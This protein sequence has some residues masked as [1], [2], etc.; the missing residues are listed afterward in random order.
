ME[1]KKPGLYEISESLTGILMDSEGLTDLLRA[2]HRGMEADMADYRDAVFSL[3][4][5][6]ERQTEQIRKLLDEIEN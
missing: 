2:L 3:Q 5:F 6:S 1:G 4:Q